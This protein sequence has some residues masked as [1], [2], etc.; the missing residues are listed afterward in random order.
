M[1][2]E[3]YPIERADVEQAKALL[4]AAAP[5]SARDAVPVAVMRRR[6]LSRTMSFDGGFDRVEWIERLR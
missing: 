3:V 5:L 6:G 1:V 4:T 2:D